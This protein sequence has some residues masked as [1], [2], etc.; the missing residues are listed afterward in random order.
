MTLEK[1]LQDQTEEIIEKF[2]EH[3]L[4]F[5]VA[6]SSYEQIKS[7]AD[8]TGGTIEKFGRVSYIVT[9]SG[10]KYELFT[11]ASSRSYRNIFKRLIQRKYQNPFEI[12]TIVEVDHLYNKKRFPN[13][14]VRLLLL[15]REFN[16]EWGQY[17]E[18]QLTFMEKFQGRKVEYYLDYLIFLKAVQYNAYKKEIDIEDYVSNAIFYMQNE[19]LLVDNVTKNIVQQYLLSEL[20]YIVTGKF[21]Y[22]TLKEKK[23]QMEITVHNPNPCLAFWICYLLLDQEKGLEYIDVEGNHFNFIR[24]TEFGVKES[25]CYLKIL[26]ETSKNEQEIVICEIEKLILGQSKTRPSLEI[27]C[28]Q[29]EHS[30]INTAHLLVGK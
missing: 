30:L 5:L 13:H 20:K 12:P 18:K 19:G 26:V 22:P 11:K 27:Q 6:A 24:F 15:P 29:D 14:F 7:Y 10:G 17:T 2:K 4:D 25:F 28:L 16:G 9:T 8:R 3:P 21:C 23:L 1:F